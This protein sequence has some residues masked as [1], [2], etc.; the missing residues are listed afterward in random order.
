MAQILPVMSNPHFPY[1][2]VGCTLPFTPLRPGRLD[3]ACDVVHFWSLHTGGANFAFADGSV[4][5]LSYR[6]AD[7]LP[8]LATTAG[9]EIVTWDD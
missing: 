2:A 3:D 8:A 1:Q 5:F 7:V 9:R 4:R 6:A